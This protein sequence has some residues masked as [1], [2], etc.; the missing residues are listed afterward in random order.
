MTTRA[1]T[2]ALRLLTTACAG[3]ALGTLTGCPWLFAC[4]DPWSE[5][6]A[7]ELGTS[8]DLLAVARGGE[9]DELVAV[10]VGGVVVHYASEGASISTPT[11]QTLRGVTR[12][13]PTIV[14]GDA[15][16]ILVSDDRGA[17][18]TARDS[19]VVDD[20]RAITHVSV[21]G[22]T[23][24]V[25]VASEQILVST[26]LG[27]TWTVVPAPT[28]GWGGLRAVV[29]TG[30]GVLA[31]AANGG[32]WTSS[33]PAGVWAL[34]LVDTGG[35][36]LIGGGRVSGD[37]TSTYASGLALVSATGL[38]FRDSDA[39]D[40]SEAWTPRNVSFD[41]D[42][43]AYAGG[44]VVTANGAIYD[45]DENGYVLPIANVGLTATAISG[46]WEGFVV[47]G[48][49]GKAARAYFQECV[50]GRPWTLDGE[51]VTAKLVRGAAWAGEGFGAGSSELEPGVREQLARAWGRDGQFE[52]ASV[53]SFARVV[54]ELMRLGAPAE[55]VDASREAALDE[56]EHARR[57]FALASRYAGNPVGPGPLPIRRGLAGGSRPSIEAIAVAVFEDGCINES[58][59]AAEAA[60]AANECRDPWVREVLEQIAADEREHAALAWRTLRW[61]LEAHA[62]EVAPALQRRLRE[63]GAPVMRREATSEPTTPLHAMLLRAHGRL[64]AAERAVIQHKVH[65]ELVLPLAREL[66]GASVRARA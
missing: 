62:Y 47:V 4:P 16:T 13:G 59:A 58:V 29:P 27:Q 8:A 57:C 37:E 52:H 39:A 9:Y 41:G 10:G 19:G 64:P 33:D 11:D 56:I 51:P 54:G 66:L 55:L 31:V 21:G 2:L 15:G 3:A 61:L 46:G 38:W 40:G 14:V 23:Y 12:P 6:E 20:L 60:I 65:V 34:E 25:A 42:V 53:A 32:V 17:T 24:V 44:F 7:V 35:E 26:D 36:P 63:L 18:W 45:V 1:L 43:L 50:G 48:E 28:E 30:E 5:V 49:G 22:T